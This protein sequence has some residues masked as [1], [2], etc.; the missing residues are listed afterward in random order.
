[1]SEQITTPTPWLRKP[2][3]GECGHRIHFGN[4]YP[5][6]CIVLTEE[7]NDC[8]REREDL[9]L[10]PMTEE[11]RNAATADLKEIETEKRKLKREHLRA[12]ILAGILR[13]E[14][15]YCRRFPKEETRT[16]FGNFIICETKR[17]DDFA[18]RII[19]ASETCDGFDLA[20]KFKNL[21]KEGV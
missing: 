2:N 4:R 3:L 12:E 8:H 11:G 14:C 16:A 10:Y 6:P 5:F 20:D 17:G 7:H 19:S 15:R 21:I 1:M 13:K 18:S 9:R